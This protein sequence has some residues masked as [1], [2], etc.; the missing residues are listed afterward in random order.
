[1]IQP[2]KP[3]Q[4]AALP[5]PLALRELARAFAHMA[6][7]GRFAEMLE[8]AVGK[9]GFFEEA[10][11]QLYEGTPAS[12]VFAPGRLT[13]PLTGKE[14]VHGVLRVAG[15]GPT[16][17]FGP[18]DIHLLSALGAVIAAAL[19]HALRHGEVRRNL[20]ILSFVLNLAPVGL[21]AV[22]GGGRVVLANDLARRWLGAENVE[23][24]AARLTPEAVGTDWRAQP[25]FHLRTDGKLIYV[26][27]HT[28]PP[29]ENGATG[30]GAL[31]F[32]DLSLEQVRLLDGLQRELY[33]CR[34][35][36]Q[37]LA[38]VLLESAQPGGGLLRRLP[39]LR[40]LLKP[41][42]LA[43]PY[44]AFRIGLVL[45]ES[46]RAQVLAR[47]RALVETLPA[48]NLK[49]SLVIATEASA[50][51][52]LGQA[53]EGMQPVEAILRRVLL[54]HDDYPAVN[55]MLA[56]VLGR[57]YDIVKSSRLDESMALLRSRAFDGLVTE[58]ELRA[59]GSGV[60]LALLAK[61]LQPS[62]RPFFTT[63]AH[64][65]RLVTNDPLLAD[66]VVIRKPFD[67]R[68]LETAVRTALV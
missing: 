23:A 55:D 18:E 30:A 43:G 39:E 36:G 66:H 13:L 45:P 57:H 68:Q 46:D 32:T 11:V 8:T 56:L 10:Q 14:Q 38:F 48:E 64:A 51:R 63:V 65:G 67:V 7:F 5:G 2:L 17:T 19:D 20:E 59:G 33:R 27:A 60:E 25:R 9:A 21:V 6:D 40:S 52:V 31:V 47:L 42:E 3:S 34:W 1:M 49:A 28:L 16:K 22:D 41:G 24:V 58:V 54:L 4:R 29:L 35:L 12:E 15:G 26:E 61:Q 53:L 50:E 37:K 44:D 62:I